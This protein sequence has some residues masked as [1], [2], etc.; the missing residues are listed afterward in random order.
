MD[1]KPSEESGLC[2]RVQHRSSVYRLIPRRSCSGS[3]T[4]CF[5]EEEE[6]E[7]QHGRRR[8]A[9]LK[10]RRGRRL[11]PNGSSSPPVGKLRLSCD[12]E[13]GLVSPQTSA[14][15]TAMD[16]RKDKGHMRQPRSPVATFSNAPSYLPYLV[17]EGRPKKDGTF[18]NT[19]LR[20]EKIQ[21]Q[22]RFKE[23]CC[24]LTEPRP[25]AATD[26]GVSGRGLGVGVERL[27]RAIS[28]PTR[29][30]HTKKKKT[31]VIFNPTANTV[32]F[33]WDRRLHTYRTSSFLSAPGRRD[34]EQTC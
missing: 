21:V 24:G 1:R 15:T 34:S 26:L 3:W 25:G 31:A 28:S 22:S 6:E 23:S 32:R 27:G 30:K 16:E 5:W 10:C 17:S 14:Q 18:C 12:S 19:S 9:Q 7:L 20:N 29:N 13:R 4:G 11:K 2:G 8:Q 33:D